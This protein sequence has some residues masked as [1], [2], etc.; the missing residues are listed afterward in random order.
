MKIALCFSGQPRFINHLD[1]T[2]FKNL[3]QDHEIVTYA[4]F[5]WDESYRGDLFHGKTRYPDDYEPIE[6]FKKKFN[7][8]KII[9]EKYP[10]LDLSRFK[11]ISKFDS[12][13]NE[14]I[15]KYDVYRQKCQWISN[16][17]SMDLIDGDFDLVVRMR[18]DLEFIEKVP[19]E[20]CKGDGIFMMNGSY[21]CGSGRE[22][23]DWFYCGPKDRMQQFNP[24]EIYDDFYGNG[25]RHMHELIIETFYILQIPHLIMDLKAWLN[26]KYIVS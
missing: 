25:I 26:R 16:K 13:A 15:I 8:Q 12:S 7:P 5:W 11:L 1:S 20:L 18:T 21:K 9:W 19:L 6:D 4:H 17:K 14:E 22:Y 23:C 10:E 24:L 3:T 2:S